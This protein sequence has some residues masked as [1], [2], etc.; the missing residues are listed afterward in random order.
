MTLELL[1]NFM[2]GFGIAA[3]PGAVFFETIRRT[4]SKH[5]HVGYFLTGNMVGVCAVLSIAYFGASLLLAS[6]ATERGFY[7]VSGA[8]LLWIGLRSVLSRPRVPKK[9]P[10]PTIKRVT[11]KLGAFFTGFVLAVANP[12]SILFWLS[13]MGT[14]VG[15]MSVPVAL[16][17]VLSVLL[18]TAALLLILVLI[19]YKMRAL[20]SPRFLLWLT[21]IFGGTITVYG[22]VMI[23]QGLVL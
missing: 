16:A 17:N 8:M 11:K 21:R 12:V 18:G 6:P 4:L 20:L 7:F 10:A 1:Q 9:S 15:R 13:L 19:T 22:V 23:A 5:S 3:L 2:L 14:F